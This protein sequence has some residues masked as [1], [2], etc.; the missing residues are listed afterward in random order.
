[1]VGVACAAAGVITNPVISDEAAK[2]RTTLRA[3]LF[4]DFN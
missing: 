4:A 3:S 1:M 2:K